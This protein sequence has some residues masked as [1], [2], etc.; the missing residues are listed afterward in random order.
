MGSTFKKKFLLKSDLGGLVLLC[1][2]VIIAI[3]VEV[4]WNSNI[5][6]VWNNITTFKPV[7]WADALL[8]SINTL[9]VL[10]VTILL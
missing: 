7:Y 8:K 4:I 9:S 3:V 10:L 6:S 5:L 2:I 1:M